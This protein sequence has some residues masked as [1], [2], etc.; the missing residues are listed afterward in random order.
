MLFCFCSYIRHTRPEPITKRISAVPPFKWRDV[1]HICRAET[2]STY[3]KCRVY[4][5]TKKEDKSGDSLCCCCM[6]FVRVAYIIKEGY[7]CKA[8][9]TAKEKWCEAGVEHESIW[10]CCRKKRNNEKYGI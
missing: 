4:N 3:W 8:Y 10:H 6:G 7:S 1:S 2:H 5:F 9:I